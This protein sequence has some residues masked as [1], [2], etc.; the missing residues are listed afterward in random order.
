[1]QLHEL[2]IRESLTLLGQKKISSVELTEALLNRIRTY[3][4]NLHS[5]ITIR[6]EEVRKEAASADNQRKKK[7]S[8]PMLGIP[9]ALKDNFLTKG[10]RTTSASPVLDDYVPQYDS[11]YAKKLKDAGAII[12]G[13]TN[14]D[15]WGH[16]SS[17][18]HTVHGVPHNPYARGYVTGGSSSG[19]GA[20]VAARFCAVGSGSDTGGSN[21]QPGSYCNV[22]GLK[23]TYGRVSR[24]GVIAMA[25]ST[26][27]IAHLTRTIWDSAYVLSI[28]AG[29][30]PLDATTSTQ[31]VNS[32]HETLMNNY[33]AKIGIPKQYFEGL[34]QGV[35]KS[36]RKALEILEKKGHSLIEIS[37]PNAKY[38]YPVYCITVSSEISSNLA[39]YDGIRYGFDRSKFQDEARRRIMIGTHSLST[40]YADKYYKQAAKARTLLIRDYQK[41]FM[42]VDLIACPVY[43]FPPFKHQDRDLDPLQM[44]LSDV[45]TVTA[46]LTGNPGISV[47]IEFVNDLPNGLQLIAPH[48]EESRLFRVGFDVEEEL[49][50]YKKKPRLI[51]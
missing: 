42:K 46:N 40:G 29:H 36:V 35:E 18:E 31:K 49:Q 15:A 50:M 8:K 7:V 30:D 17:G 39:R 9:V 19:S 33:Q 43:P 6:D 38:A 12:I 3:D 21:R 45:L 24:Y 11:T 20:A 2:T 26:D 47:P 44:Y 13:K 37:L 28:V 51:A 10:I 5:F 34:N 4:K 25:S 23:P 32:Y 27:S 22:V 48:F 1:M 14:L 41:A 16:G